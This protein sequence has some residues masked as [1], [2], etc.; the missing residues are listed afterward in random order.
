MAKSNSK[1]ATREWILIVLAALL[2]LSNVSLALALNKMR[3]D[4]EATQLHS[5]RL[6]ACY[7]NNTHPCDTSQ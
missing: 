1:L 4:L 6:Q 5:L 2:L 3:D 7:N